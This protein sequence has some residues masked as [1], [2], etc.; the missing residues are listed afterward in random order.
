MLKKHTDIEYITRIQTNDERA[1]EKLFYECKDFFSEIYPRLFMRKDI[2][3]DIFQQSFVKLW[4]EIETCKIYVCED[5]GLIYRLNRNGRPQRLLCT[6]QQFLVGIARND[7]QEWVRHDTLN[8]HDMLDDREMVT[9]VIGEIFPYLSNKQ[10]REQIVAACVEE[11]S[12][13]CRDI[14]TKFYY[15]SMKFED[16][17]LSRGDERMSRNG[18]KSSKYKCM[19][20]LKGKVMHLFDVYK[21]KY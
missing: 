5:D 12:P 2:M 11:L 10:W 9:D 13:R 18:L 20:R 4:T 7:Y 16:I 21:I 3:D 8:G 19:E 1:T 14:L 17:L 15:R 6:L